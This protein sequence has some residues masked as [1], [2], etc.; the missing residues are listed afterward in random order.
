MKIAVLVEGKTEKSFI[1]EDLIRFLGQ[2][3][4][5]HMPEFNVLKQDGPIPREDKLRRMV[6]ILLD[7]GKSGKPPA[8]AVIALTDVYTGTHDF[9][10]AADAKQKMGEWVGDCP[11]FHPH[12]AQYDF[13]AWLLP[14]WSTILEL[15]GHN[16]RVPGNNPE[17]VDHDKPPSKRI[18]EIFRIGSRGRH[19]VKAR[20]AKRILKNQDLTCAIEAC[21]ELRAFVN[22]I[23]TLCDGDPLS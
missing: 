13:E 12:A 20:D 15:A 16:R 6:E 17:K 22:T 1:E 4:S 18:A 19:Y 3:L 2:R 23:L 9:A 21:P 7:P 8:D 11:Q 14:Y 5:G 10:D